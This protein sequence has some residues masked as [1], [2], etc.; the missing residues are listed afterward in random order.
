[1]KGERKWYNAFVTAEQE[2]SKQGKKQL[3][4]ISKESQNVTE[5]REKGIWKSTLI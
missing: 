1:M 3:V 4:F 5:V 2:H